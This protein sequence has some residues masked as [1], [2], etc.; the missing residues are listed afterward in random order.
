ATVTAPNAAD[1]TGGTIQASTGPGILLA[2]T[3]NTSLTRM[4]VTGGADDG[5]R[6]SAVTGFSL[7]SSFIENNGNAIGEGGIDFGD[8][9]GAYASGFVGMLGTSAITNS[10]VSGSLENNVLIRSKDTP[11]V[12]ASPLTLT[13]TGSTIRDNSVANGS[14][15]IQFESAE[16]STMTLNVSGCA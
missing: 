4:R 10:T 1:C 11:P 13:V 2:S 12:E 3:S 6:G 16:S 9:G 8:G 14:D 7:I 15:G 5:I